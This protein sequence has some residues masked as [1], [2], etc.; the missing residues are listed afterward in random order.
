[1][2]QVR[3]L[4]GP[5]IQLFFYIICRMSYACQHPWVRQYPYHHVRFRHVA[6]RKTSQTKQTNENHRLIPILSLSPNHYLLFS[7][8]FLLFFWSQK[9]EPSVAMAASL[10][11]ATTFLQSAKI[12]TA[13]SRGS[14]HLRST[15]TVGKSFGLETSSARLTCSFQS[16]FKD[17]AGK[18]SDAV[19]ISGFAL[20]T[21]ALVVS[22]TNFLSSPVHR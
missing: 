16:N 5:I 14:A 12:S 3:N 4:H 10:Q 7:L 1:M 13:P 18:C 9:P 2:S 17:F 22:V 8:Y 15:Q 11:S 6:I 20:A 19:K 21:S